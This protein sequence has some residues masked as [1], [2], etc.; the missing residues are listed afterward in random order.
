MIKIQNISKSFRE[1]KAVNNLSWDIEPGAVTGLLGPNGAGKTTTMRMIT[2]F[3]EP[4]EGTIQIDGND[5]IKKPITSRKKLGYLPENNPLY[6]DM[7]TVEFLNIIARIKGLSKDE[8]KEKIQKASSRVEIDEVFFKPLGELSKGYRQRVGLA[9]ALLGDP[10]I[11]I[12]DEPTEGLDP[13]QR[14]EIREL[15]RELGKKHTVILSTHVMQEVETTCDR[16]VIL[17]KGKKITEGSVKEIIDQTK[18]KQ[19]ISVE[20]LGD[21]VEAK[22]KEIKGVESMDIKQQDDNHWYIDIAV[23]ANEDIR[24]NI[25]HL[26]KNMD[27]TLLEMYQKKASLEE[28]FREL[29][30]KSDYEPDN[31]NNT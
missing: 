23:S 6:E 12:L 27:W 18:R 31:H 1:T 17:N 8:R 3:L 10:E 2:G 22:I 20:M 24:P 11:L 13:N 19:L 15:T 25:F 28:V 29:T 4:D 14:V 7:L 21:D 30:N 5:I 16:M 9:Q 26:A